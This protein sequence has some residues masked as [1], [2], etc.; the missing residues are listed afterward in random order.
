MKC[1]KENQEGLLIAYSSRK[2]DVANAALVGQHVESCEACR[3]FVVAQHAVWNALDAWDAPAVSPDFDRRL[4]RRIDEQVSWWELAIR[5][6][7]PVFRHALP[8]AAAAGV[9]LVAGL[10]LDRPSEAP[11]QVP[12]IH[13]VQADSLQPDQV[14]HALAE[15]EMLDHFNRIMRA[16]PDSRPKM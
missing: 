8:I 14:E 9:V 12:Q 13:L 4:Y 15:I 2:L 10:L 7:R 11:K 3:D 6:L 1:P 5:P 16:D